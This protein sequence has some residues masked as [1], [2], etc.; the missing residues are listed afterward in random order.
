M[1]KRIVVPGEFTNLDRI[2][3]KNRLAGRED[4]KFLLAEIDRLKVAAD[5]EIETDTFVEKRKIVDCFK[6]IAEVEFEIGDKTHTANAGDVVVL[7]DGGFKC[8]MTEKEFKQKYEKYERTPEISLDANV[9]AETFDKIVAARVK[10]GWRLA[11]RAASDEKGLFH[12]FWGKEKRHRRV[13]VIRR[14]KGGK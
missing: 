11:E 6:A 13:N 4:I 1:S 8:V 7:D 14:A 10:D 5:L 3:E 12:L 2:R 9:T